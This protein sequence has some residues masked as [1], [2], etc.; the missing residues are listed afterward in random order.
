M[1]DIFC[2]EKFFCTSLCVGHQAPGDDSRQL[3]TRNGKP[4]IKWFTDVQFSTSMFLLEVCSV[5]SLSG[6]DDI[7]KGLQG[8]VLG[9]VSTF[10]LCDDHIAV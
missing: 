6:L 5:R 9:I 4:K 1:L 7:D 10:A 8:K 2:G 3:C